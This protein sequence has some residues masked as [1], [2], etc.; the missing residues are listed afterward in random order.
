[1]SASGDSSWYC[2]HQRFSG[3]VTARVPIFLSHV[4]ICGS[5][6]SAAKAAAVPRSPAAESDVRTIN[7][8]FERMCL[9]SPILIVYLFCEAPRFRTIVYAEA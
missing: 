7:L 2:S 1:M 5:G 8:I 9:Y 6:A 3:S 4:G